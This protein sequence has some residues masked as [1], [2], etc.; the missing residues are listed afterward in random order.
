MLIRII[1][2][3]TVVGATSLLGINR[4]RAIQE[5]YE[6]MVYLQ[7]IIYY[8]QSEI[9]YAKAYLSEIFEVTGKK[10][11]EPY[12]R[13]LLELSSW[14]NG[15]NQER[16]QEMWERS[17]EMYLDKEIRIPENEKQRLKELGK[18]FG[19]ADAQSQLRF[20]ELYLQ[21]IRE[22]ANEMHENLYTRKKLSYCMGIASGVFLFVLLI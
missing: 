3:I 8:I 5:Q 14:M 11:K 21:Q 20:L 16:F 17:I 12:R 6:E 13:W 2:G 18:Q 4:A 1:G 9:H 10:S 7:K 19:T 22:T 15:E